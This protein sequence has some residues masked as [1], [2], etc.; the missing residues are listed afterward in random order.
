M[1]KKIAKPVKPAPARKPREPM[2]P[3]VKAFIRKC[4]GHAVGAAVFA[5]LVGTGF[6]ASRR[7]VENNSRTDQPPKVVLADQPAWMS[8]TLAEQILQDVRPRTPFTATDHQM[9]VGRADILEHNPW[10][11]QVKAVR[12]IY[13]EQAGDTIEVDCVFRAPVA[14]VHWLDDYWYVDAEGVRLPEKLS[15]DQ[16]AYLLRPGASPQLRVIDGVATA[17]PPI[18]K[19]WPGGEVQ[20]A[21]EIIALLSEKQY[22]E[23]IKID[24]SNFNGR[25][26]KNN[27]Q[28]NLITRYGTEVRWGQPPSAKAF[29]NEQR[30]DRKLEY[31]SQAKEQTGRVDMNMPWIDLRFDSPTVP[32]ARGSAAVGR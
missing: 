29:F 22:D 9:L 18:A 27:S 7:Y 6:V 2:S 10:V 12:R 26:N 14:L 16:V 30:V 28:L 32:D 19:P 5:A 23:I 21:I 1:A 24:V 4:V 15:A 8:A 13:R 20:A 3:E 31:L 11:K 25:L 17:R